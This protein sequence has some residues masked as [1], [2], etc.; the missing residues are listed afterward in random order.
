MWWVGRAEANG[1]SSGGRLEAPRAWK[2]S[3]HIVQEWLT[4]EI[5]G[6]GKREKM[7][8]RESD[9]RKIDR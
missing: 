6:N 7:C 8:V 9:C 1:R 5:V 2:C 4:Q 3:A